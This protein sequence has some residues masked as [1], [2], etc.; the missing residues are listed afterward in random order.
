LS[1]IT[2]KYIK[3]VSISICAVLLIFIVTEGLLR[4]INFSYNTRPRYMEFNFPNPHELYEI[5][6]PDDATLWRLRPGVRMGPGI[7]PV[8]GMGFRGA[9]FKVEKQRGVI[10]VIMMGDSVTFGTDENYPRLTAECLGAGYEVINAGVPGYTSNQGL[11]LLNSRIAPLKPDIIVV[12]Y[13]W[14]DHWL[15]QGFTDAEQTMRSPESNKARLFEKLRIYQLIHWIIAKAP[16]SQPPP[17][18]AKLRVSPEEYRQNIE[19]IVSDARRNGARVILVTPPS[20]LSLGKVPVYLYHLK[21]MEGTPDEPREVG[22]MRVTYLHESYNDIVRSVAADAGVEIA[23]VDRDWLARG[24]GD[25]FRNPEK[26]IIHPN[27]AGYRLIAK[28]LCD[29]ILKTRRDF[30]QRSE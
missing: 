18:P 26:D 11:R 29:M 23:D 28:T 8:N 30:P 12:M 20:A 16:L 25:L 9:E 2:E 7:E 17:G 24:V 3:N 21:F 6:E 15:A 14:N 5:F 4:L 27:P 10:R 22:V 13:G 19:R 1:E